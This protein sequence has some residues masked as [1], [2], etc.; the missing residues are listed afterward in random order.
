M[1][2]LSAGIPILQNIGN[3]AMAHW[4][5]QQNQ[6]NVN[7]QNLASRTAT[8]LQ[9]ERS[10]N[11]WH[12]QNAYNT[13]NAQMQR[14]KEAG[15]NPNLIYGQGTH[16]NAGVVTPSQ[17]P[18]INKPQFGVPKLNILD[19]YNDIRLKDAQV[20]NIQQQTEYQ[21][22]RTTG[23]K[24]MNNV[25]DQT[26]L[27]KKRENDIGEQFDHQ[28]ARLNYNTKKTEYDN[29]KLEQTA[30]EIQNDIGRQNLALAEYHTELRTKYGLEP[31]DDL[32]RRV[33]V[34]AIID[35]GGKVGLDLP[36]IED[37]T[38]EF[39]KNKKGKPGDNTLEHYNQHRR[40]RD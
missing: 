29:K 30:K 27:G 22:Q 14:F 17:Q 40:Q 1:G 9:Y 31:S 25:L 16:G 38:N 39:W 19:A 13:P 2:I 10:I 32:Y 5:N 35:R 21:Q 20:D 18:R 15:L 4:Q 12:R 7:R 23:Q 11:D 8:D 3:F 6:I 34:R 28:I 24:I 26:L 36:D 37:G 33:M